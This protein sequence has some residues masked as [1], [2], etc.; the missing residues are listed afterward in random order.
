VP[1]TMFYAGIL[2][3]LFLVLSIR[4]IRGR[5]TTRTYTG[6]GGNAR[7]LRLIRGHA[8]FAEYVPLTLV[9]MAVAEVHGTRAWLLHALGA[10]LVVARLLHGYTFAFTDHFRPGRFIGTSLTLTVLAFASAICVWHGYIAL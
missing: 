8:N 4:V 1:I 7:M 10:G 3:A 9:L 6:D 5:A 2:G